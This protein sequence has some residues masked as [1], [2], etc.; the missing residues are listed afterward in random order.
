MKINLYG[1]KKEIAALVREIGETADE[2]R[3]TTYVVGGFVRDLI[4]K[5]KNLDLDIVVEGD[6]IGFARAF[7][8]KKHAALTVYEKFGTATLRL[9]SGLKFDI[10][11][12][13]KEAYPY[14]GALPVVAAGFIANDL[15]RRDFTINAMAVVINPQRFG[16]L[17]DRFG[18]LGDLQRKKIRVLHEESFADDPTRIL[19]AVRRS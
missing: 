1:L 12:G 18:G 14:S 16:E 5:R 11:M 19:R 2:N 15:F 8:K 6:A 3:L 10:A 9:P 7:S 17:I 4:L 13:R